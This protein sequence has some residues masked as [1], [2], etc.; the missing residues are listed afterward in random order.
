MALF[1]PPSAESKRQP[2]K[3]HPRN[4]AAPVIKPFRCIRHPASISPGPYRVR[5]RVGGRGMSDA[6]IWQDNRSK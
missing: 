3:A 4:Q 5:G 6:L 1:F 2:I